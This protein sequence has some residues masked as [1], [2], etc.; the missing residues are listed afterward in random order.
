MS[1]V[2]LFFEVKPCCMALRIENKIKD[3][4][5]DQIIKGNN[6]NR[7]LFR[8]SIFDE[9]TH[10]QYLDKKGIIRVHPITTKKTIDPTDVVN[11]RF[12]IISKCYPSRNRIKPYQL[13]TETKSLLNIYYQHL[14]RTF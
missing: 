7:V 12:I 1:S 4:F 9:A 11:L 13:D 2:N 6:L 10:L 8:Q 5:E 3:C 14:Q